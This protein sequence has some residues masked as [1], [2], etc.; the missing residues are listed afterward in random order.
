MLRL[1]C[2]AIVSVPYG[3]GSISS[4]NAVFVLNTQALPTAP[5]YNAD[6]GNSC[7]HD[8]IGTRSAIANILSID[9]CHLLK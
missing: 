3:G 1:I 4:C 2:F 8:I 6:M 9:N 5:F 7:V